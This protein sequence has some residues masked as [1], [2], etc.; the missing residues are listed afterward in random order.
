M[1]S[2]SG[3]YQ[4]ETL[5]GLSSN[6]SLDGGAGADTLFGLAGNDYL[7]GGE[8]HLVTIQVLVEDGFWEEGPEVEKTV[9]VEDLVEEEIYNDEGDFIGTELVDYGYWEIVYEPGENVWVP[10]QYD[11]EEEWVLDRDDSL[12]GGAGNDT[13]KGSPGGFF[14][15]IDLGYTIAAPPDDLIGGAGDD[16]YLVYNVDKYDDEANLCRG[17]IIIE[18]AGEG[19]DTIRLYANPTILNEDSYDTENGIYI[20]PDN[21]ENIELYDD[22]LHVI[23]NSLANRIT[24]NAESNYL[25]GGKG[26]DT[27]AGGA[28]N[29]AYEVDTIGDL[30]IESANG[31]TDD[32]IWSQISYTLPAQVE[33]LVLE[34]APVALNG[35][36]NNLSNDIYG[37]DFNN[38][39][40][41]NAGNDTLFGELGA[42]LLD[43]GA[44]ADSMIGGAGN[45][46]YIYDNTLDEIIEEAKEGTDTI[47]LGAGITTVSDADI[48][49]AV[50]LEVVR[51]TAA[52]S[53]IT[54]AANAQK[55]GIASLMGGSGTDVWNAS[56]MKTSITM[57]AG[58][59]TDSLLGGTGNDSISS[60]AG[61]DIINAGRGLDTIK[62][63]EGND[64]VK[65]DWS[66]LTG[67]TITNKV[68]KIAGTSSY[69]GTITAKNSVG[70][71]LSQVTLDS[72]ESIQLNGKA[73]SPE[74]P[75][76]GVAVVRTSTATF[77][78]EQGGKVEYSVVLQAQPKET[79]N[80]DFQSS[81]LTEGKILTPRLSF[82]SQNWNKPQTLTIQGVDDF[83][84]D[85]DVAYTING[86]VVTE[87]LTYNRITVSS[88]N[89]IN[90]DDTEDRPLNL[91][92]T[93]IVDYLT[94]QNGDDRIYGAG[95]Q[96]DLRGGRGND[97]I[98]GDGDDDRLFGEDG[99]DKLYGGYDD[100]KLDGG[101]G[102]DE[103]Y[104]EQGLDTLLGGAGNDIL[105]GGIEAD[106]MVGGV[107]N[108][109]YY[110]DNSGDK[111]SDLGSTT[112]VDTVIVTQTVTYT[113]S[114]NIENASVNSTA[115][116]GNL[117]GNTL[118]NG[119]TGNADKNILDGGLGNDKLDGGAGADSLWGGVGNDA[120][121][122]GAGNDTM[123]GGD[124]VDLA[125]FAAAGI[126]ISIDLATGRAKGDGT[127]LLFDIE[128]ILAGEGDDT[129][130]GSTA[131][132]DLDGGAGIDSLN[133]GAGND[134]MAGCFFGA[135][136]GRGEIDTLVGGVGNDIFQ[137]GWASGRFY[138]DGNT[139]NAGRTDYI[140]ITDF[141]VGQDKLQLDGAAANYYLAASGV[142][143]V[144]GTGLYAEQGATD[145]LIAIIR[146]ANS[147]ALNATNTVNTA[148]LL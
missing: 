141:T 63:G 48:Y 14:E 42:D 39:L 120:M 41:G 102:N 128:N 4:N 72:I 84:D 1:T 138:D 15:P 109:T 20:L 88:I 24:G 26:N 137:L 68:E 21:I 113:L 101:N 99:N 111:I 130:L 103:T 47:L 126:D 119:L 136:G 2:V 104:G 36:G 125:D 77:T 140:L 61:N 97:K 55:S 117:T 54:L 8:G 114:A 144:S 76:P 92:G 105:D 52:N 7:F 25:D 56:A 13:L 81:D 46:T 132:N 44:G 127:D 64:T 87:D 70:T 16:L 116:N 9:W 34:E 135:N 38:V 22:A 18:K 37:N 74:P 80:V 93:G 45:D 147:T 6:D 69:K 108:D 43:G 139:A 123:R 17:D 94:G 89:I 65:I 90:K 143:G 115:G 59:G 19:T 146:S 121:I 66:A 112:D 142:T 50:S 106:S 40:T 110:V 33:D 98:Y 95:N 10:P 29:D 86:K 27:L 83:L 30:V 11:Y 28:G 96:D 129:L 73:W 75:K 133:G 122:G 62:G 60:G 58:A 67:A 31:G 91:Q 12:L 82:T 134:T 49:G 145:E 148:L 53:N 85:K 118:N 35:T 78:T 131:A 23:G 3:T 5:Y 100:D 124:G 107:G 71:I 79:V 51:T 32:T 57:D